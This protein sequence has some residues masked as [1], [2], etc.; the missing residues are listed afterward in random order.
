MA[1]NTEEKIKLDISENNSLL[2][3]TPPDP[4]AELTVGAFCLVIFKTRLS[5]QLLERYPER[6]LEKR[7]EGR[8]D[9][10]SEEVWGHWVVNGYGEKEGERRR[11]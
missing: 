5:C 7:K 10:K 4:G 11:R 8:I 6:L 2:R 1:L 9:I 3:T